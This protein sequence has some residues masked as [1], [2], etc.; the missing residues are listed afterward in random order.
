MRNDE[1]AKEKAVSENVAG[2]SLDLSVYIHFPYCKSRCPY[3]DFFRGLKPR[4]FDESALLARYLQDINY[5]AGLCG[6]RRVKSVFFGGG[7]PSLLRPESVARVLEEIG[8]R[9][10]LLKEAE[11]SLEANPNTYERE[12]FMAFR[13]AGVNR[14]SLG[15]Q[16]LSAEGLK[17][18]GRTHSVLDAERAIDAGLE[19]FDKF[20]ADLIYAR[21]GQT[22]EA[23]QKELLCILGFGLKH[24]SLYQLSLEEG[25]VF[26]K[27]KIKLP[28]EETA[29][30]LYEQTVSFLR[31]RNMERYEVSNFAKNEA[32]QSIH[33]L[34]YWQG[35][36]YIGIGEG[37]HGRLRQ[38]ERILATV[39]GKISE[40]LNGRQRAEELVIMGLRINRGL[41]AKAFYEASG[42]KLFDFLS[43][44]M[45][46][47]LAQSDL[48]CYD[49]SNI[50]LTDKGF[51]ILDEI[52]LQLI[53]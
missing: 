37:A 25:T 14:L 21:P 39:D 20:S 24:L 27:K 7:T 51:L 42:V 13:R 34:V 28:D 52:I 16:A 53:D 48:L 2:D 33:N 38:D 10:Y 35:G 11:I 17:F 1:T 19:I 8:E 6:G 47:S 36:D 12:K 26:F 5:F 44:K 40:V 30:N 18:L 23:W 32:N 22:W 4:D 31:E 9:F 29:A 41:N 43:E 46:K 49:A 3:C 15:V 45:T 50:S